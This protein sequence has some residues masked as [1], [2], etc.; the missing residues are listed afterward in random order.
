MS[1]APGL[2]LYGGKTNNGSVSDSFRV[3]LLKLAYL[4]SLENRDDLTK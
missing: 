3:V 2:P 4:K 1:S